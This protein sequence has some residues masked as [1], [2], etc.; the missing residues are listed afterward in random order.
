[1]KRSGHNM[2]K[3]ERRISEDNGSAILTEHS[4][5]ASR[6]ANGDIL[7]VPLPAV[8]SAEATEEGGDDAD[9][10]TRLGLNSHF[11]TLRELDD[12]GR[13]GDEPAEAAACA[14][15]GRYQPLVLGEEWRRAARP[16]A[17]ILEKEER[18]MTRPSTSSER[19]VG[20]GVG[21][22]AAR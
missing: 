9:G 1:M 15:R 8:V 3:P 4:V 2:V 12:Q 11:V 19:K 16:G 22:V 14:C 17:T 21:D 6:I 10:E 5:R 18:L 13:R 7:E 20:G